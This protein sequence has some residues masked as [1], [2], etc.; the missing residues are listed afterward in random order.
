[1]ALILKLITIMGINITGK[2]V[3][4]VCLFFMPKIDLSASGK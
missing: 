4:W 3:G 2:P 1:M